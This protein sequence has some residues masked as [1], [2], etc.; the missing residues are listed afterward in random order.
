MPRRVMEGRVVSD[1]MHKTVTVLIERRVMDP[2]YKKF[3][4]RSKKYSAH[5]EFNFFKTG[6]F[7]KIEE[8]APISKNKT[9]KIVTPV[10][11]ESQVASAPPMKPVVQTKA[12]K[13]AEAARL[14]KE[15][16]GET[17][18]AEAVAPKPAKTA[19]VK[20]DKEAKPEPKAAAK[21]AEPK[22]KAK[23]ESA[24]KP[25]AEKAKAES[26]TKGKS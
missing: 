5:D 3:I 22:A 24:A 10:P 4:R 12:S 25:K 15:A 14:A 2:V 11:V 13:A 18:V 7:V 20:A 1:K 9:W 16:T 17:G 19:P 8:C 23:D 21:K 6:D 26:K